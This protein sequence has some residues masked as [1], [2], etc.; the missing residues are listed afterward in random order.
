MFEFR[1][2][3]CIKCERKMWGYFTVGVEPICWHCLFRR[4]NH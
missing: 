1:D 2:T 4:S 3:K